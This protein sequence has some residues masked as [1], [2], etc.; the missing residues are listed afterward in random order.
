VTTP[1]L[2]LSVDDVE[3]L[4]ALDGA[5][6]AVAAAIDEMAAELRD[7]VAT[8][9]AGASRRVGDSWEVLRDGPERRVSSDVFFAA[10]LAR[11]TRGHGPRRAPR[12]VFAID[13][14]V[15][16]TGFVAGISANPFDMRAIT[17]TEARSE[18]V[19]ARLIGGL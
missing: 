5:V 14:D 6:D 12:L 10:F 9:S 1:A 13:G 4:R 3:L 2:E 8:E 17:A 11:G 19:I 15:I 7:Q 18:D 16:R